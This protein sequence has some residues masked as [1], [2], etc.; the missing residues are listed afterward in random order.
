MGMKAIECTVV[1][2][3]KPEGASLEANGTPAPTKGTASVKL[4][5]GAERATTTKPEVLEPWAESEVQHRLKMLL[6]PQKSLGEP[7]SPP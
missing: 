7:E 4:A 5:G 6:P 2:A 3:H 1:K